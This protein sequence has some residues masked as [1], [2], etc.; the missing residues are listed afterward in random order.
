[1]RASFLRGSSEFAVE[2]DD[3]LVRLYESGA[4]ALEDVRD[5]RGDARED[6]VE[7]GAVRG[8]E[9][10]DGVEGGI[11]ALEKATLAE[12]VAPEFGRERAQLARLA[13]DPRRATRDPRREPRIR[14]GRGAERVQRV[15]RRG[16][17]RAKLRVLRKRRVVRRGRG[18]G[19][20]H[21]GSGTPA[22]VASCEPATVASSAVGG[23]GTDSTRAG[24]PPSASHDASC[25][26]ATPATA[27]SAATKNAAAKVDLRRGML[28]ARR[29]VALTGEGCTSFTSDTREIPP[30][31]AI[32]FN[33]RI[34]GSHPSRL[35]RESERPTTRHPVT[36][37]MKLELVGNLARRR[38]ASPPA[39]H[40]PSRASG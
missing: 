7:G 23:A 16:E 27:S 21:R 10:G 35:E 33:P 40:S 26:T 19:S 25:A 36:Q 37:E 39:S 11:V 8:Q 4:E 20:A 31:G 12:E 28:G 6:R 24:Q 18:G 22:P 30:P 13:G 14:V 2:E 32:G 29:G 34:D 5:A 15:E 3:V 38:T 1:M 9:G 17:V